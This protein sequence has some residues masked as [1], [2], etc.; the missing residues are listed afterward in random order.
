MWSGTKP[1]TSTDTLQPGTG[2]LAGVGGTA[3]G[4]DGVPGVGQKELEAP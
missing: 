1:D 3:G 2:G 4:N